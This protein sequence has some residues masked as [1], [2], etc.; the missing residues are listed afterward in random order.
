MVLSDQKK[1]LSLG[2]DF[3]LMESLDE[4]QIERDILTVLTK[5]R[6]TRTGI[7]TKEVVRFKSTKELEEEEA[8]EEGVHTNNLVFN[9]RTLD[10]TRR[11]CTD[12]ISN[13]KVF[14]PEVRPIKEE[15]T[16]RTRKEA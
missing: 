14:M 9:G 16:I 10:M 8:V 13:R 11:V 7:G 15:C 5:V 12:M 2:P 1:L 6:W 3:P 4:K